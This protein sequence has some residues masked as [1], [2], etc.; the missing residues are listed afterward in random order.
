[1]K[2]LPRTY[3]LKMLLVVLSVS[4]VGCKQVKLQATVTGNGGITF[5]PEATGSCGDNCFTYESG[6]VVTISAV[7]EE[8]NRFINWLDDCT[9]NADS[10]EI[11]L[12]ANKQITAL[13]SSD[14]VWNTGS[15]NNDNW[16]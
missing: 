16:Q 3:L 10:C 11:V 6:T 14:M 12:D 8:S 15:W 2:T 5:A 1:M 13:F 9:G 7:P 4:V